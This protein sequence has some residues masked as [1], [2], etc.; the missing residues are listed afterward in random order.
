M[1]SREGRCGVVL[2]QRLATVLHAWSQTHKRSAQATGKC[3][4]N[5]MK[6]EETKTVLGSGEDG[7]FS[8]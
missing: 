3:Q 8:C 5:Q 6:D 1:D 4:P 7:C 2:W